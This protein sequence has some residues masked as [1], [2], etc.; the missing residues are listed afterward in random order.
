VIRRV[1]PA[2]LLGLGA[3]RASAQ[4]SAA[5]LLKLE[6]GWARALVRR[7]S[8][9]FKRTLAAGFVYSEDD[10]SSTRDQVLHDLV[11]PADTVTEAHNEGMTV[12]GF[13]ST[14]V[15][16]GWLIVRGRNASGPYEHRYRFTDT[17]MRQ[18][19]RWRIVAAHD[20]L[21]PQR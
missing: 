17:W 4:T 2:L 7:D 1:I 19:S 15:V 16:T 14:A 11:S 3:V 12:H 6:D 9:F 20:Y 8:A 18:A 13:G 5:T 10:R 21:A